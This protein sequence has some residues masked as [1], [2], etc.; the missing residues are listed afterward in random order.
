MSDVTNAGAPKRILPF[1]APITET[2]SP[3]AE[4]VLRVTVGA[5][6]IPHGYSKLFGGARQGTADF[7]ANVGFEPA[8]VLALAVA[9]VEFVGG[10]ALVLGLLTR[11]VAVAV[12][13]FMATAVVFHSANGFMWTNGG[14]EYPL[15]WMIGA[16]FFAVRGGGRLS[17]DRAIGK[18][19]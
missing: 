5:L 14:Y 18:E 2:L 12:A 1:A 3:L 7:F 19:F 10:M 8:F 16:L 9:L 15:M 4:P 17:L 6:L 13:V 11:P